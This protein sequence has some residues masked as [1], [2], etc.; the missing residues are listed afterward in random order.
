LRPV[1]LPVLCG[2]ELKDPINWDMSFVLF[3]LS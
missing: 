2:E 1:A 3:G